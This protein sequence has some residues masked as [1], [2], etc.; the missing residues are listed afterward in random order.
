VNLRVTDISAITSSVKKWLYADLLRKPEEMILH[1][2][3]SQG[4]LGLV[5]VR[6]KSLAC[7]LRTFMELSADPRFHHSLYLSTLFRVHVQEED[8]TSCSL[9]PYYD[10]EFFSVIKDAAEQGHNVSVMTTA[11]WYR[12][13]LEQHMTMVDPVNQPLTL[14]QCRVELASPVT[15]WNIVWR[16]VRAWELSSEVSCHLWKS[17]HR[18]LTYGAEVAKYFPT[19]LQCANTTVLVTH[20][21]TSPTAI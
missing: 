1:R 5:S 7:L 21:L 14:R 3:V 15:D 12:L 4:G 2:P 16:R 8:I 13:L 10:K 18:L 6:L 11:Q 19:L 9:P 20:S 17:A